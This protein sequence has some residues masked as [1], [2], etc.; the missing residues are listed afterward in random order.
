MSNENS[1]LHKLLTQDLMD[2]MIRVA[3]IAFVVVMCTQVVRPFINIILWSLILAIGLYPLQQNL[4]RRFGGRQGRAST[5]LV[6]VGLLLI[7]GPTV[8]LGTSFAER[9]HDLYSDFESNQL[10][11]PTPNPA[12][13]EWPLV[14]Q[15]VYGAWSDAAD[16]LPAYVEENKEQLAG[17]AKRGVT[18]A[19]SAAG[20]ILLFLGALIIAGVIMAYGDS[21]KGAIRR[22]LTR[23]AGPDRGP[24][25]QVLT[26]QTVRS[27]ATG[28]IGVAFIQALLLGLGF[29]MAGIPGAGILAALVM[30]VGILQL[31]AL[32]I[33]LP[34]IAY[35]WMAGDASTTLNIVFTVYL[36]IAGGVDN[37]LKPILLGR[38]VDAPMPVILIGA[39]GGM[40]SAGIVGLFVGAVVLAVGYQVFM[41]WVDVGLEVSE[42]GSADAAPTETPTQS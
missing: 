13:A 42:S 3:L 32:L 31:P 7:G 20:G 21:G 9:L 39:L 16:N 15:Q 27:V 23:F 18:A 10:S 14:G 25:L 5:A 12:V 30:L 36:L 26:T 28:V 4:A 2:V 17:L 35:L 29:L 40:V 41:E 8:M 38:G 33:S 11:I 1:V 24:S 22:I 37:V 34:A 19:K 6:L